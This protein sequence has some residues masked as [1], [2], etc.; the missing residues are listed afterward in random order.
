MS[1]DI[2]LLQQQELMM[3]GAVAMLPEEDQKKCKE[4]EQKILEFV[5]NEGEVGGMAVALAATILV[6]KYR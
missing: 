5:E 6:K 1:N 3:R 2:A 4:L